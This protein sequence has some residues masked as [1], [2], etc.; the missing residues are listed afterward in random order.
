VEPIAVIRTTV[1]LDFQVPLNAG[2]T[3]QA[4][5]QCAVRG[6][7][8]EFSS[9]SPPVLAR[10]RS[11]GVIRVTS[12]APRSQPVQELAVR[13]PEGLVA[14]SR[15]EVAPPTADDRI[16]RQNEV[17]LAGRPVLGDDFS[18]PAILPVNRLRARLDEGLETEPGCADG[19]LAHVTPQEVKAHGS[20]VAGE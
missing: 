17:R 5:P 15:G 1:T 10:R 13:L 16:Q 4:Q 14:A 6:R 18:H 8:V 7:E 12:F 3:V 9:F 20:S 19:I 2:L 11:P